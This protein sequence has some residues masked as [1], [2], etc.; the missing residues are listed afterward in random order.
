[1][2]PAS[3]FNRHYQGRF[4]E[5]KHGRTVCDGRGTSSTRLSNSIDLY[6][7]KIQQHESLLKELRKQQRKMQ[8]TEDHDTRQHA[9]FKDL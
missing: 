3:R 8:E 5:S 1:M 4:S 9:M 2:Q 6:G 7:S